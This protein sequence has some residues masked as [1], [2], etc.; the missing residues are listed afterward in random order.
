M[1][2][3]PWPL[4][5]GTAQNRF[6]IKELKPTPST[7]FWSNPVVLL[8][9]QLLVS[10]V[11]ISELGTAALACAGAGTGLVP[12]DTPWGTA[13]RPLHTPARKSALL[14]TTGLSGLR[15]AYFTAGELSHG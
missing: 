11:A 3:S 6:K 5:T 13:R 15:F 2:F 9:S 1:A 4:R 12:R 10:P 14:F 7:S 8:C